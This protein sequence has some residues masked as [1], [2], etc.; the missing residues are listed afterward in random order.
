MSI[1]GIKLE[2]ILSFE[3]LKIHK[4]SD[5]NCI[6]GI[7]NSG[8]SNIFKCIRFFYEALEDKRAL[9]PELNNKYST[10]GKITIEYNLER[11]HSVIRSR[12]SAFFRHIYN[13]FFNPFLNVRAEINPT[14]RKNK[15][16]VE[17]LLSKDGSYQWRNSN[18]EQRRLI[19]ILFP[20]FSIE[21]RHISLHE[22]DYLW[23]IISR[24]KSFNIKKVKK[25]DVIEFIGEKISD[26]SFSYESEIKRIEE[27]SKFNP[28][29]YKQKVLNYI[30]VGLD[31]DAFENEG[32]K[33]VKQSD[34]TNSFGY[35]IT[36]VSLL[37]SLS[38][39]EY[40]CP[41]ILIDEPEVG[42]HP[43]LSEDLVQKVFT[44]R[45]KF[46]S[47]SKDRVKGKYKTPFPKIIISTH[48][49]NIVKN[50][51]KL[52]KDQHRIIQLSK[53]FKGKTQ[54]SF[55]RDRFSDNR[56]YNIIN[57]N[58]SRL[59]FS[60]FI[61]FVEGATELE[62]F[63][64]RSLI[65]LFPK[66]QKV[67]IYTFDY[68]SLRS[69][70]PNTLGLSTPFLTLID[71]D[72]LININLKEKKITFDSSKI[73]INELSRKNVLKYPSR[74]KKIHYSL[75]NLI[76]KKSSMGINVEK[77]NIKVTNLNKL[78]KATNSFILKK[79]NIFC[80]TTTT[81]G[82]LISNSSISAFLKWLR[83]NLSERVYLKSCFAHTGLEKLLSKFTKGRNEQYIF[84]AA[85]VFDA[86]LGVSLDKIPED[87]KETLKEVRD[88]YADGVLENIM[89]LDSDKELIVNA[90]R[91]VFCG[92]TDS[93]VSSS[94]KHY[95]ELG[96]HFKSIVACIKETH[97]LRLS[98]YFKKTSGWVTDFLDFY[99]LDVCEG[100]AENL[101]VSDFKKTFPELY[102]ILDL[103]SSSI[104]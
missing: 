79:N 32:E 19:K 50:S 68:L 90:L 41:T 71:A 61:L 85:F 5:I 67:D 9:G 7:N 92:K 60:K 49:Q 39:R 55:I 52:F 43:K 35:I 18:E 20:V 81:E 70:S 27:V 23:E 99:M 80:A 98:D 74:D 34:G 30:K 38:R 64:N 8:K 97:L 87:F 96:A 103:V 3:S 66:L 63:S 26:R 78:I 76:I 101:V 4:L 88:S 84:K 62:L 12:N 86:N 102:E 37:I 13:T 93:L 59:F 53:N 24:T 14:F 29:S 10:S 46:K 44:L 36:A 51:I 42:L 94:N 73:D 104:D 6:V 72:V 54:A 100:R 21:T 57:D 48:S 1:T 91:V 58:E 28:Y 15:I 65:L 82:Y 45:E 83:Y 25:E 75:E 77:E 2:N 69:L 33:L 17:L 47:V 22:W 40:I 31:G 56:F 16:S 11:I 95:D 89:A